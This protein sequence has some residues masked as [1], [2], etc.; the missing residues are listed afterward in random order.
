MDAKTI[1]HDEAERCFNDS[2]GPYGHPKYASRKTLGEYI[3][4][5]RARDAE[6]STK[7]N[8]NA[9]SEKLRTDT[10]PLPREV[11]ERVRE[12]L[13]FYGNESLYENRSVVEHG[14]TRYEPSDVYEDGGSLAAEALAALEAASAGTVASTAN[15]PE[16][17]VMLPGGWVVKVSPALMT[18]LE[19]KTAEAASAGAERSKG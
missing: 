9:T 5:Q 7:R 13:R 19:G 2:S 12:A 15:I 16:G 17:H 4:Q 8:E 6:L 1:T 14:I 3:R 11:V 10:V 18:M